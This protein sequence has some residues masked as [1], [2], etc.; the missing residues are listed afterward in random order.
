MLQRKTLSLSN[1]SLF[2]LFESKTIFL[3]KIISERKKRII[4]MDLCLVT[5][6][7]FVVQWLAKIIARRPQLKPLSLNS[8]HNLHIQN[9][10]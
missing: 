1:L 8:I 10:Q 7:S 9:Q 4:V 5:F 6:S 2:A 3:R